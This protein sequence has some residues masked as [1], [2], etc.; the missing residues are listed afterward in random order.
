[1]KK[2][3][4]LTGV[5]LI[6]VLSVN[7]IVSRDCYSI[8]TKCYLRTEYSESGSN[9]YETWDFMAG[10]G[11]SSATEYFSD[12]SGGRSFISPGWDVD[13][14]VYN[15]CNSGCDAYV[16]YQSN[17]GTERIYRGYGSTPSDIK[18]IKWVHVSDDN[19]EGGVEVLIRIDF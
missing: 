9:S 4:V 14:D 7:A 16:T 5:C 6:A 15:N 10:V 18:Q 19:G 12:V 13:I 8:G 17:S 3:F 11:G 2:L 1:M